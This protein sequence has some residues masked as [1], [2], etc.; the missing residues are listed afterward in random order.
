M[1]NHDFW[2]SLCWSCY[3]SDFNYSI[4]STAIF[5][6]INSRR[7]TLGEGI[8]GNSLAPTSRKSGLLEAR[9]FRGI[10]GTQTN[11]HF[12]QF[13][14][15]KSEDLRGSNDILGAKKTVD[16]GAVGYLGHG[17]TTKFRSNGCRTDFDP[18]CW[19]FA[20]SLPRDRQYRHHQSRKYFFTF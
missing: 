13:A 16:T 8:H 3:C 18:D 20:L 19:H 6:S 10:S 5:F 9:L 14:H 2:L 15:F 1:L 4:T 7:S 11:G 12:R 17:A